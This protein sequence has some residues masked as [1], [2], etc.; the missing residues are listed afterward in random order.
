MNER[1]GCVR[2][3]CEIWE[4]MVMEREE[5]K[6]GKGGRRKIGKLFLKGFV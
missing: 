6:T 2:Y 1:G 3:E 4:I 5:E